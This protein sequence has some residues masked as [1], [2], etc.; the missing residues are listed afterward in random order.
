MKVSEHQQESIAID[1]EAAE[2]GFCILLG[3]TKSL[4][5]ARKK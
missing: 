4:G 1:F 3:G 5:E 2:R